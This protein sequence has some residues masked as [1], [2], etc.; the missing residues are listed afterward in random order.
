VESSLTRRLLLVDDEANT[1]LLLS[2]QISPQGYDCRN[3]SRNCASS[4]TLPPPE[5][6]LP[7]GL[8]HRQT[9][10]ESVLQLPVAR[11]GCGYSEC[12]IARERARHLLRAHRACAPDKGEDQNCG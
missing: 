8:I 2:E 10:S 3:A 5:N 1:G 7:A 4:R 12:V 9:Q 11:I 6:G